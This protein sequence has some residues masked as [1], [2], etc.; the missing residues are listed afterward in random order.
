MLLLWRNNATINAHVKTQNPVKHQVWHTD[1][2]PNLTRSKSVTRDPVPALPLGLLEQAVTGWMPSYHPSSPTNSVKGLKGTQCTESNQGKS[3]AGL[4]LSWCTTKLL[5]ERTPHIGSPMQYSVTVR[6]ATNNW[7]DSKQ[8]LKQPIFCRQHIKSQVS[9]GTERNRWSRG[10]QLGAILPKVSGGNWV[11]GL[12][13]SNCLLENW[14]FS[15][16]ICSI[17]SHCLAGPTRQRCID[18]KS[19][20]MHKGDKIYMAHFSHKYPL[21]WYFTA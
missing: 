17:P 15:R 20:R 14:S 12:V 11:H 5:R 6:T 4:I 10:N 19:R 1:P 9:E 8:M 16:F 13:D 3:F 7:H 2:W 18:S 21:I